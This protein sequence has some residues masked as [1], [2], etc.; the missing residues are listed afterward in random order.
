MIS[1]DIILNLSSF[2]T[3]FFLS[4]WG[5]CFFVFVYRNLGGPK[6]GKDSLL[7]FNFM[8]FKHNMLSNC[9]LIFLVLGYIA[10]AIAEYRSGFNSLLLM[11]NLAGGVSFFFFALYGKYFYK[12]LIDDEKS[13]FF[14][15]VFLTK[16]DLSLGAIFLWLSRFAY[17]TWLIVFISK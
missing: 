8:F 3:L 17:I 16:L 7:Y 2:M 4:L 14:I 12:G 6:V 15:R 11:S 10:A 9:A 1:N 13:F 5:V